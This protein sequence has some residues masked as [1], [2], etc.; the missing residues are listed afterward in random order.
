VWQQPHEPE[1]VAG[2]ALLERARLRLSGAEPNHRTARALTK[3][4]GGGELLVLVF[5]LVLIL[6]CWLS[7]RAIKG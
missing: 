6:R 5:V 7:H 3:K 4:G 1:A 2:E